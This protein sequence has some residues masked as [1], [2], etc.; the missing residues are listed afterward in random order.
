MDNVPRNG[1]LQVAGVETSTL[2]CCTRA[3]ETVG[4]TQY[5]LWI[6]I[7]ELLDTRLELAGAFGLDSEPFMPAAGA[8]GAECMSGRDVCVFSAGRADGVSS[9]PAGININMCHM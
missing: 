9:D 5:L 4:S 2:L 1:N 6:V 8:V 7:W 3:A